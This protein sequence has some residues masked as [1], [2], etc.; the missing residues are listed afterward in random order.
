MKHI[1][2]VL[3]V[4]KDTDWRFTKEIKQKINNDISKRY[5]DDRIQKLLDKAAFLD[6]RLEKCVYNYDD[7]VE[8]IQEEALVHCSPVVE[9]P[10]KNNYTN[11]KIEGLES[12]IGPHCW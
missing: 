1:A 11:K 2:D 3:T 5:N 9:E 6:P 4:D 8:M 10:N 7:T 12:C